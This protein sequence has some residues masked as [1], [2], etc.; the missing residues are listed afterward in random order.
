[1]NLDHWL[2]MSSSRPKLIP[3]G[4]W[5]A[6]PSFVIRECVQSFILL[7]YL[8]AVSAPTPPSLSPVAGALWNSRWICY[9]L[10]HLK[11]LRTM[12]FW[13]KAGR[14][15]MAK[16]FQMPQPQTFDVSASL[17]NTESWCLRRPPSAR[18]LGSLGSGP[19]IL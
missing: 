6:R 19:K 3:M 5:G 10:A 18:K 9:L 17:R 7:S 14:Q 11:L 2:S 16:G 1:M 8:S 4:L 15:M 13:H 12:P